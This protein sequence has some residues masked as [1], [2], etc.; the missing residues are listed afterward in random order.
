MA[1][2][3]GAFS[4]LLVETALVLV[5]GLHETADLDPQLLGYPLRLHELAQLAWRTGSFL[6]FPTFVP[7][8]SLVN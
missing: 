2:Q 5:Q 1:S 4:H 3:K 8:L 6:S 7:S